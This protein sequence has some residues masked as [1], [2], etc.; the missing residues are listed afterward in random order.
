M[1]VTGCLDGDCTFRFGQRWTEERLIGLREPHL[2]ASVPR[3]RL[4]LVW[5]VGSDPS[6]FARALD[7]LRDAAR[8]MT[9]TSPETLADHG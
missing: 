2:R 1:L 7:Q 8:S 4:R 6:A 9:P 3:E 5:P